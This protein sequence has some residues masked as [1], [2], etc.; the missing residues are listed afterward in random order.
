M[1]LR[2]STISCALVVCVLARPLPA[3]ALGWDKWWD[4]LDQLSGPG[5]FHGK[6]AI[7]F[8]VG[9]LDQNRSIEVRHALRDPTWRNPCLYIDWRDLDATP[10]APYGHVTA[11]LVDTGL[12]IQ[13]KPFLELGAGVGMASFRTAVG[14]REIAKHNFTIT[15]VRI[16]FRPLRFRGWSDD[17]RAG[18]LQIVVRDTVRFGRLTAADFGASGPWE[19]GTE[20]LIGVSLVFD[21]LQALRSPGP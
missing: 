11:N 5:P 10:K 3:Q 20:Q 16:V 14:D 19:A 2:T 7:A 15:P 6:S 12:S 21:V 4:Y 8:T 17:T 1:T 13:V 18:F 9:C